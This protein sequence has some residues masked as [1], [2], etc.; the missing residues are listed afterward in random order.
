MWL[1]SLIA[2]WLCRALMQDYF[3]ALLWL[4][5]LLAYGLFWFS[6]MYFL[7][8]FRQN[9]AFNAISAIGV[10][11]FFLVIIPAVLNIIATQK[12]PVNTTTLAGLV[13]RTSL[14]NEDDEQEA[15]AVLE[16]FFEHFPKYAETKHLIDQ[17][18][19]SKTYAAFTTLKDVHS[20]KAVKL[21]QEK[22]KQ[23]NQWLFQYRF[24]SPA[25]NTQVLFNQIAHTDFQAFLE[26]QQGLKT[27]HAQ[28]SGFYFKKLFWNQ[29][30]TVEDYQQM[31][32]YKLKAYPNNTS[33]VFYGILSLLGIS[34]FFLGIARLLIKYTS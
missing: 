2:L 29:K 18:L 33:P 12:Y 9:S 5:T 7:I 4:A 17:N 3:A 26:F 8:T 1:L 25:S 19:L 10:W 23:R 24:I 20:E 28:I 14:E 30:I 34:F 16:E 22:V 13:R 27:F 21:Y 32:H 15:K 31:P 6:L 11:L